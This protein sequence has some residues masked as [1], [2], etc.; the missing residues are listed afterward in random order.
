MGKPWL[1]RALVL[2]NVVELVVAV[3]VVVALAPALGDLN[4]SIASGSMS[5]VTSTTTT[6]TTV[7]VGTAT[8]TTTSTSTTISTSTSTTDSGSTPAVSATTSST[9]AGFRPSASGTT[10]SI[11]PVRV[12]WLNW[13]HP[14][15]EPLELLLVVAM[16]SI[17][18]CIHALTSLTTYI[19]NRRFIDSWS[20]WY[21]IRL[22]AGVGLALLLYFVLRAGFISASSGG[23]TIN[24]YGLAAFAGLSGMF[25]KEATDMLHDVYSTVFKSSAN[26]QRA[27]KVDGAMM[28]DHVTPASVLV[29]TKDLAVKIYGRGFFA[30]TTAKVGS[31]K[32]AVRVKDDTTLTVTLLDADVAAPGVVTVTLIPPGSPPA[33]P[34]TIDIR[35]RPGVTAVTAAGPNAPLSVTGKGFTARSTVLIGDQGRPVV[36]RTVPTVL[37]VQ[38]TNDDYQH[39]DTAVLTVRNP[40]AEGGVSEPF[41]LASVTKWP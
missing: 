28:I 10:G 9:V 7:P 37:L 15:A 21:L 12:L 11:R 40:D 32:R 29:G 2:L 27:D 23:G 24:P 13:K 38:V 35:V 3:Y 8:S 31:S 30:A 25:S 41:P 22:P 16:A 4:A 14:S 5:P 33:P 18:A 39:R 20:S 36:G 19:G 1:A 34:A 26:S 17:G 6:S